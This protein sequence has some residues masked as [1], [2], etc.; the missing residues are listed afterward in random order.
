MAH[1]LDHLPTYGD[2][3][4]IGHSLG[5]VVAIDLLDHLPE[6]L[7]VR[8]FITIGSPANIRALHEGSERLLKKF[9]YVRVDDWSNFLYVRDIVTGGRGLANTFPG[10]QDFVLRG[11]GG[12]EAEIYLGHAAVAG[13]VADAIYPSRD[14]PLPTSGDIEVR[15]SEAEASA[16]LMQHFA[17]AVARNIKDRDAAERYGAALEILRDQLASEFSQQAVAGRLLA[18]ELRELIVGKLPRL[19]HRWELHE[20]IRQLRGARAD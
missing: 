9:P 18:P 10:A 5:S 14:V 11:V 16:L 1:I 8:R 7:H 12:H 15:M 20:A 13:L 2:V 3:L 17:E 6:N 4:L 19:P